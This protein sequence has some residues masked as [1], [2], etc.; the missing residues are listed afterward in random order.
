MDS[1][2]VS[3]G[4]T[5]IVLGTRT[6]SMVDFAGQ[7]EFL[8]S[9]QLLLSSMHTLCMI[10][11][12]APSFANPDHRHFGSWDYWSRFLSSLGDRRRGSLLLAIS[13]IDKLLVSNNEIE[14]SKDCSIRDFARIKARSSGVI[15]STCPLFLDYSPTKIVQT[16]SNV[17]AALSS[18]LDEV[19]HSWWVP[20]TR[21]L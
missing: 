8:V 12:P 16:V 7:V 13:Q 9:H 14:S 10:I 6:C 1:R 18:S 11:Q 21:E 3:P 20:G 15:S 4:L 5:T 2:Y 17:K 19:G